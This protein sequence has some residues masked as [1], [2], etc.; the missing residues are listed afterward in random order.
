MYCQKY[1]LKKNYSESTRY[2]IYSIQIAH[3]NNKEKPQAYSTS[4]LIN[5]T[6]YRPKSKGTKPIKI[7]TKKKL[8]IK[9][10]YIKIPEREL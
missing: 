10:T 4:P 3:E 9:P 8:G 2:L 6:S 1:Q 7:P 5:K